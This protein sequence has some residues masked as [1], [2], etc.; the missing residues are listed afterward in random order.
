VLQL[1]VV[2]QEK[3]EADDPTVLMAIGRKKEIH[4]LVKENERGIAR[5]FVVHF[6]LFS[7]SYLCIKRGGGR[8]KN[9]VSIYLEKKGENFKSGRDSGGNLLL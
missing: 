3:N 6:I 7:S 5:S 9:T 2:S 1:I 8:E 4:V